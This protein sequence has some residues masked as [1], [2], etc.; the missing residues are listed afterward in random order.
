MYTINPKILEAEVEGEQMLILDPDKG[1]YFELNSTS[2][3]ILKLIK[4]G[5]NEQNIIEALCKEFDCSFAQ[6]E[7]DLKALIKSF[8]NSNILI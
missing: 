2:V 7:K 5:S 8:K 1:E 4:K 6:A 3:F